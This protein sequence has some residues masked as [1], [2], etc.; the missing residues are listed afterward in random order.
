MNVETLYYIHKNVVP[1]ALG[2]LPARMT[3]DGAKAM[4]LAIGLQ[5]SR[6]RHRIQVPNGP[7][8]GFWQFEKG[9]GVRGVLTHPSTLPL[10]LPVLQVLNYPTG[11]KACYDAIVHNDVLACVFARLLLWSVPG[12]LP[13]PA[14]P[15]RAWEYYISGWR[16]G[17][18]HRETWD[19]FYNEAWK[20]VKTE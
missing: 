10:L 17:K 3:S 2:L 8:H 1:D 12:R 20:T 16:P 9:G 15:Q 13:E 19:K 18:P 5:E 11:E 7:A 14:E 6:F 4:I